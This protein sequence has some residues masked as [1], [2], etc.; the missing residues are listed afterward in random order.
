MPRINEECHITLLSLKKKARVK[1]M[2]K[3]E[4]RRYRK[5]SSNY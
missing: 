2:Q 1:E 5:N 3:E 4:E